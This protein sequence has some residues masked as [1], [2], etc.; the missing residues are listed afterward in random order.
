MMVALTTLTAF[1]SCDDDIDQAMALSG[2]WTGDFGMYYEI[3]DPY[4]GRWIS[5]DA[6]QT[7]LVF[8]PEY[9]YA[10]YGTGKQIDYYRYGPYK[11]QYYYFNWRVR[12]GIVYMEYPYD[13]GLNVAINDYRMSSTRFTGWIGD[14]KFSLYKM[15][16]FYN[17]GD[18]YGDYGYGW[19]DGWYWD[20]YYYS[21]GRDGKQS[22]EPDTSNL[23]I[24]RGNRFMEKQA[25]TAEYANASTK[26]TT[27]R[28]DTRRPT[29]FHASR[30]ESI[31]K[32]HYAKLCHGV[33]RSTKKSHKR[34]PK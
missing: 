10:T 18:Y 31:Q 3:E 1:T 29:F 26:H 15:R 28:A 32:S 14:V 13:P 33:S 16:D 6:S 25:E 24:R 22:V 11:Y 2:E 12:N 23:N 21:K 9:E 17:W 5:F 8:Y 30:S 7:D 34:T 4:T 27:G 19:N 20:D